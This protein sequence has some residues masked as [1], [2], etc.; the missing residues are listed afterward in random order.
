LLAFDPVTG[1]ESDPGKWSLLSGVGSAGAADGEVNGDLA[2]ID[3]VYLTHTQFRFCIADPA[4]TQ[5]E[6]SQTITLRQMIEVVGTHPTAWVMI[7]FFA[8]LHTCIM[9]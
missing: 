2:I 6:W 7:V 5:A 9:G 3:G 4:L 8:I 1:A